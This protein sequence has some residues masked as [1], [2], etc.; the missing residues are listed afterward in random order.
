LNY[1]FVIADRALLLLPLLFLYEA[2]PRGLILLWG[3]GGSRAG[4]GVS[5]LASDKAFLSKTI[6][7]FFF[8]IKFL[9]VHHNYH[10]WIFQCTGPHSFKIISH[11]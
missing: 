10:L 3:G 4:L 1:L 6:I 7:K 9:R 11:D 5:R 2:L 8:R